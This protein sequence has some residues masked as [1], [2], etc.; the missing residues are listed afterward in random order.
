MSTSSIT[1]VGKGGSRILEAFLQ[2][3]PEPN[4]SL[5]ERNRCLACSYLISLK[6]PLLCL[7]RLIIPI[8]IRLVLSPLGTYNKNNQFTLLEVQKIP[9]FLG[10]E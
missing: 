2:S 6:H 1:T 10:E 3:D 5:M 4:K 9:I 7:T 8:Y